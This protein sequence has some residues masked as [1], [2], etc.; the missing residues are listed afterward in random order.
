MTDQKSENFVI[1]ADVIIPDIKPDIL[2]TITTS[3]MVCLYKKEMN[4]N[5]LRFDGTLQTYIMYLADEEEGKVRG[6]QTNLD[7][8]ESMEFEEVEPNASCEVE[9]KVK[10]IECKILN[11]R[12]VR[13]KAIL[14]ASSTIYQNE[15]VEVI[16]SLEEVANIQKMAIPTKI[17]SLVGEGNT[18][19][20]AKDTFMIDNAD[21]LAEILKAEMKLIN[22]DYKVSYHKVLLKADLMVKILYLTEDKRMKTIENRIPVM[23]FVDIQDVKEEDFCDVRYETR[24]VILKPNPVEEHSIYVECEL[25]AELK[26]YHNAQVEL[27]QDLYSTEKKLAYQSKQI[28][29]LERTEPV[30]EKFTLQEK[31]RIEELVGQN[32]YD[33]KVTTRLNE[34]EKMNGRM[35]TIGEVE[36]EFIY[37]GENSSSVESKKIVLPFDYT[38]ENARI[39]AGSKIKSNITVLNDQFVIETDDQI[40]IKIELEFS[41]DISN[42]TELN[43]L[44]TIEETEEELEKHGMVIYFVKPKDT[45]WEIAKRFCSTVEEIKRVNQIEQEKNLKIGQ[46]LYIPSY[47][48]K[49]AG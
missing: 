30:K 45:L 18:K 39:E 37:R 12:K 28:R 10:S 17:S 9:V 36:V 19:I 21:D 33:A 42:V 22:H 24:N 4:Q 15:N 38:I 16:E 5:K 48:S 26:I 2:N 32:I 31:Q 3:G 7:F 47:A 35:E 11:G 25:E 41:V 6:L 46:K 23:G 49:C 40:A 20:F 34:V 13:V 43:L 29:V 1:E 8:T 44:E 14:E 27:I